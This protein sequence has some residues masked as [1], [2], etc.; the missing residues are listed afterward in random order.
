MLVKNLVRAR[1]LQRLG[2][3]IPLFGTGMAFPW[4]LFAQLPLASGNKVEDIELGV[5]LARQGIRVVL[6]D[7]VQVTSSAASLAA[8][9]DQ[10]RRWEHGFLQMAGR[11]ALPLIG[12][13]I[14]Y[15][16]RQMLTLG[17]HMS[18]PPLALHCL[19]G[20]SLAAL[21]GV[22]S[23]LGG[24]VQPFAAVTTAMGFVL[25]LLGVTWMRH[26]REVIR[27]SD[28]LRAPLYILW[29]IPLYLGY[30]TNRQATWNRTVRDD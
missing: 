21:L 16:S 19:L 11:H 17:L 6:E 24:P 23:I 2:K 20:A 4:P 13:G 25:L 30:F 1:G 26:G 27:L 18:V 3:S 10:R 7:S 15:R 9:R 5:Y 22:W 12:S 28:L 8:S 29:K 14:I